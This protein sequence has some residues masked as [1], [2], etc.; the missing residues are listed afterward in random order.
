MNKDN[1]IN[2]EQY[3]V[4][5]EMSNYWRGRDKVQLVLMG[6]SK[7]IPITTLC[8]IN[9]V[10]PSLYYEWRELF[11]KRGEEGLT[12]VGGRS[13]REMDLEKKVHMLERCVGE[14]TLEKELLKKLQ[15]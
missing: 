2:Y 9:G 1:E 8:K 14:L 5:R 10:S 4:N 15:Y 6:L 7:S 13:K 11:I 3:I 12:G